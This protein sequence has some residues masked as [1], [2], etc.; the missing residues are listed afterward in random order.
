MTHGEALKNHPG[1]VNDKPSGNKEAI[2]YEIADQYDGFKAL[3][4]YLEKITRNAARFSSIL[5]QISTLKKRWLEQRPLGVN[6]LVNPMK[7][8][9]E[10][11]TLSKVYT[12]HSIR[13][14]ATTLWSNKST[15]HVYFWPSKRAISCL[16]QRLTICF[17]ASKLQ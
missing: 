5:R 1:G 15:Y 16:L 13:A 12:N 9:N 4:L 3:K 2:M 14:R 11:A 7:Q 8:I 6:M 10:V 17:T